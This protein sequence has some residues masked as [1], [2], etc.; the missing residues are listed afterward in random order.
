MLG[1]YF[2]VGTYTQL[3]TLLAGNAGIKFSN[4]WFI[5]K[6]ALYL[7]KMPRLY[8]YKREES[9]N[10]KLNCLYRNMFIALPCANRQWV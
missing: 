7:L 10:Q 2:A 4:T 8:R 3:E 9:P 5:F 1:A 6:Q